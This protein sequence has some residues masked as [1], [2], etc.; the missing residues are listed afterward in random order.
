VKI[1]LRHSHGYRPRNNYPAIMATGSPIRKTTGGGSSRTRFS[2]PD[3]VGD[4]KGE[5]HDGRAAP[6]WRG[7]GQIIPDPAQN[8]TVGDHIA[9][10][11]RAGDGF[12]P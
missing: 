11:N 8:P 10:A 7:F 3:G 4:E 1:E 5:R 6:R 2:K 9:S 12:S